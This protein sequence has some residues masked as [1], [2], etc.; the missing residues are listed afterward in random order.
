MQ[1]A[2]TG[3]KMIHIG[4]NTKSTIVSKGISAGAGAELVSRPGEGAPEGRGRTQLHAVRLDARSATRAARTP[5]RTSRWRTTAPR[6]STRPA[7]R[8]SARTRSSTASSAASTPS[9]PCRMI[10][11]RLLQGSVQG[12]AD[13][14]R[15]RGAAAARDHARRAASA[16]AR[17]EMRV[18]ESLPFPHR[19]SSHRGPS[20]LTSIAF[21]ARRSRICTPPSTAR[22]SSRASPSP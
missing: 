8:R 17:C 20:H 9:T 1:Q 18:G 16:D 7:R 21:D 19:R 5:S 13:G 4:R 6:S 11:S 15:A 12:A 10:V 14:V 3:T 22:R 2:D